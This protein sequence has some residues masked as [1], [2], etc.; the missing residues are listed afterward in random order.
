[1][2]TRTISCDANYVNNGTQNTSNTRQDTERRKGVLRCPM[3]PPCARRPPPTRPRPPNR[4]C[5]SATERILPCGARILSSVSWIRQLGSSNLA[6]FQGFAMFGPQI[7][8][9]SETQP[10]EAFNLQMFRGF[11][12]WVRF[13]Q[14]VNTLKM[15]SKILP[16][17]PQPLW[18]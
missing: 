12:A 3:E 6:T 16:F 10:F 15:L 9:I 7:G 2:A 13:L 1:M 14:I 18:V 5:A 17:N 4:A 8:N 11:A